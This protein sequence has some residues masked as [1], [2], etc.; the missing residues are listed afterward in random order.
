M[1][2]IRFSPMQEED[3]AEFGVVSSGLVVKGGHDSLKGLTSKDIFGD[4][5]SSFKDIWRTDL[6]SNSRGVVHLSFPVLNTVL[7]GGDGSNLATILGMKKSE[8]KD[9]VECKR[10]LMDTGDGY[11]YESVN[12]IPESMRCT[13]I[14][15]HGQII[16][17]MIQQFSIVREIENEIMFIFEDILKIEIDRDQVYRYHSAKYRMAN[18]VNVIGD[19]SVLLTEEYNAESVQDDLRKGKGLKAILSRLPLLINLG[20]EEECKSR[21][22]G[23]IYKKIVV[24]PMSMRPPIQG[25]EDQL[26]K[27]YGKIINTSNTLASHH[28]SVVNAKEFIL[29]YTQLFQAVK[30][31]TDT[32]DSKNK[33]TMSI[34][35]K[36]TGKKG[37]MR[38]KML[39][40][41]VDFSGRSV[42]IVN[43]RLEIDQCGVP[44]EMLLKLFS[45]HI[46][47]KT[48]HKSLSELKKKTPKEIVSILKKFRIL[49]TVPVVL[50]RA[51]TLHRLGWLG[52]YV[53][54]VKGK[55]LQLHPLVCPGYNADFDGDQ[56]A[57]HVPLSDKA[58]AEVRGLMLSTKN[59]FLPASGKPMV[60]PR[61]EIIYGMNVATRDYSDKTQR[62]FEISNF[63]ELRERV[64]NH[65]IKVWDIVTIRGFEIVISGEA[66]SIVRNELTRLK[67]VM[68]KHT[69]SFDHKM[70]ELDK[71]DMSS[72]EIEIRQ[73]LKYNNIESLL[74]DLMQKKI[75]ARSTVV[76][77]CGEQDTA[78]RHLM[79]YAMPDGC[80]MPIKEVT[81]ESIDDYIDTLLRYDINA[82]KRTIKR[83]MEI[84]FRCAEL[85][86]PT[87]SILGQKNIKQLKEP[88]VD[89]HAEME[90]TNELHDLGFEDDDT[91]QEKFQQAYK[92]MGDKIDARLEDVLGKDNGF[93]QLVKSGARGSKDNLKQIY[94]DKGIVKKSDSES[95][96]AIIE[97]S[98]M[99]QLTALEHFVSAY[100]ARK[101][102]VDRSQKTADIGYISR[103]GG[104]ANSE[105]FIKKVDCGTEEG[106]RVS[107]GEIYRYVYSESEEKR[108]KEANKIFVKILTGRYQAETNRYI[109]KE[110]AQ[111]WADDKDVNSITIRSPLTCNEQCCS[112]CYGDDLSI[113]GPS[114]VGTP[115]G[116]VA[117]QAIAEPQTQ[118]TMRSFSTGG[119]SGVV[120]ATSDFD[121]IDSYMRVLNIKDKPSYDPIAWASGR[122]IKE[123]Q[124]NKVKVTIEGSKYKSIT[125][126]RGAVIKSEAVKGEGICM[127][128][129]QH[130]VKELLEY[131][132]LEAAQ[133]YLVYSMYTT[134]LGKAD[135]N[136]KHFEVLVSAMTQFLVLSCDI[137]RSDLRPGRY[138]SRYDLYSG[139]L[140]NVE[141]I[142]NIISIKKLQ[143]VK[144]DPLSMILLEDFKAGL[145]KAYI[146]G[147]EGTFKAQMPRI[148]VGLKPTIGTGYNPDY[149]EDREAASLLGRN[150]KS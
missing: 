51:P 73:N 9:I 93:L 4:D 144:N 63:E 22:M 43:P 21:L 106:V 145:S 49:D 131:A 97:N 48:P 88:F 124:S 95:F 40:K 27:A 99:D 71:L 5:S 39:G 102:L 58:C 11:E 78:G 149:I 76:V 18:S 115:I 67:S 19:W 109:T 31:L 117:S 116:E 136:F 141:V 6:R 118:L 1:S 56:M 138:Y 103:L 134:Y 133:H 66:F 33:R 2:Y 46:M 101:G 85:Y 128:E 24:V 34:R 108:R 55:A 84:G 121:K 50:N 69:S 81:K 35:E 30:E 114:V 72:V 104:Y 137:S 100:G 91:F 12:N 80:L 107:K 29:C 26:T 111:K 139:S 89:F 129:G 3:Y 96:N 7:S 64:L 83:M 23:M 61:Q 8:F 110:L 62:V 132:G 53:V 140:D 25:I 113:H 52:F 14:K 86:A 147:I 94:T 130:Y 92:K 105:V 15:T 148:M 42:I 54:P 59:L 122:I 98:F 47:K 37:Q 125:V 146:Q 17:E 36:M 119:V 123:D 74:Q 143:S 77:K 79:R 41:R 142:P 68:Q 13:E 90:K 150:G 112:K 45:H 65:D 75:S 20:D 87:C 60:V 135:V 126:P 10:V 32:S 82:Y 70:R 57:V 38:D 120:D 16:E 44:E 127:A 28:R